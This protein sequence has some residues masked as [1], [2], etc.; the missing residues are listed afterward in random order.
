MG[1]ARDQISSNTFPGTL[2]FMVKEIAS[3]ISL[4]LLNYFN[5]D[6]VDESS[7]QIIKTIVNDIVD[8]ADKARL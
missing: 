6:L 4:I 7:L 8:M 2:K 1:L 3:Q 5:C